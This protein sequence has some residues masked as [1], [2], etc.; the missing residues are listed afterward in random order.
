M[1]Y[2]TIANIPM[3]SSSPEER[4]L[5]KQ[6]EASAKKKRNLALMLKDYRKNPSKYGPDQRLFLEQQAMEAGLPMPDTKIN[7]LPLNNVG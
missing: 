5:Y 1:A 2:E 7:L 6:L 3:M 4:L